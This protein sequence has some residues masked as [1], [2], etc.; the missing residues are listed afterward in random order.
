MASVRL[1]IGKT[2]YVKFDFITFE[3]VVEN[4][5]EYLSRVISGFP[6]EAPG[7]CALLGYYTASSGNSLLTF[8]DNL[9][10]PSSGST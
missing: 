2:S 6:L 1:Q 9:S 3:T 10:V 8:R 7:N 4:E 5:E